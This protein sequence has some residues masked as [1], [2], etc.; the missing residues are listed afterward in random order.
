MSSP[1]TPTGVRGASI[2]FVRGIPGSRLPAD[3]ARAPRSYLQ[4]IAVEAQRWAIGSAVAAAVA[5][6]AAVIALMMM[7]GSAPSSVDLSSAV[8]AAGANGAASQTAGGTSTPAATGAS[9]AGTWKVAADGTSF[10]GYRVDEQLVGIGAV[11]AVGRTTAVEG[12]L[13]FDGSTVSAVQVT[14][15]LSKLASDQSMRDMA[16]RQQALQTG[17]FPTATFT[18]TQ[19]ISIS[20]TPADGGTVSATAVG[21]LTLHGQTKQVAI[22]LQGTIKDGRVIVVGTTDVVFADYGIAQPTSMKVLSIDDHG[23][24]ELQLVFTKS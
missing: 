14:A 20:R 8:E 19:P 9:L 24:L 7:R 3:A 6:G 10:V 15:D 5:V 17:T 16:L 11:T 21:D 4:S 12:S 2:C 18:L 22:P 23:T 1:R 13:A